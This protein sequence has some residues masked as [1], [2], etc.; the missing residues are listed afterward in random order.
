MSDRDARY[1]PMELLI[2]ATAADTANSVEWS[3]LYDFHKITEEW[4]QARKQTYRSAQAE[5]LLEQLLEMSQSEV[6]KPVV[7]RAYV[8]VCSEDAATIRKEQETEFQKTPQ[9]PS[10]K[11]TTVNQPTDKQKTPLKKFF[12]K[13]LDIWYGILPILLLVGI[14]IALCV[15]IGWS[16][17]PKVIASLTKIGD[18]SWFW[19]IILTLFAGIGALNLVIG[20]CFTIEKIDEKLGEKASLWMPVFLTATLL[21]VAALF[22]I[23]KRS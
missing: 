15:I 21:G 4:Q 19:G 10:V 13:L 5:R 2:N 9:E 18:G 16:K 14:P 6:L 11:A 7:W 23:L 22:I 1:N 20:I 3:A 12:H 8:K 17:I